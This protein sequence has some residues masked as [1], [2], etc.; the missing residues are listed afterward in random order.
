MHESSILFGHVVRCGSYV[1]DGGNVPLHILGLSR[2]EEN[3]PHGLMAFAFLEE[4]C[5]GFGLAFP[6]S[7]HIFVCVQ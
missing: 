5:F 7:C 6:A 2:K 1:I 3:C 4:D